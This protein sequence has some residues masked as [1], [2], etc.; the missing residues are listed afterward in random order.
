MCSMKWVGSKN[1]NKLFQSPV[2]YML[3]WNQITAFLI[4]FPFS[5]F[6]LLWGIQAYS[7]QQLPWCHCLVYKLCQVIA[8]FSLMPVTKRKGSAF[9]NR[10]EIFSCLG[11]FTSLSCL[12]SLFVINACILDSVFDFPF[13]LVRVKSPLAE[14]PLIFAH[15]HLPYYSACQLEEG[16]GGARVRDEW[17]KAKWRGKRWVRKLERIGSATEPIPCIR[18][19]IKRQLLHCVYACTA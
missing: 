11:R 2:R 1:R 5:N 3:V 15:K 16:R 19:G 7:A 13:S 18:F 10:R 4:F 6:R 9:P 8:Q 17:E 12:S 14:S